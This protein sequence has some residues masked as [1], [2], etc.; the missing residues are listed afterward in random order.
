MANIS[1]APLEL[2]SLWS[3]F[4]IFSLVSFKIELVGLKGSVT[5]EYDFFICLSI[6]RVFVG[7]LEIDG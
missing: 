1:H 2:Q 3:L 4:S 7:N 5:A 6:V